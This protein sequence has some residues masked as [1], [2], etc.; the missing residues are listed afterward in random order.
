M[1]VVVSSPAVELQRVRV[2]KRGVLSGDGD[3]LLEL[4]IGQTAG[5]SPRAMAL[6]SLLGMFQLEHAP[7]RKLQFRRFACGHSLAPMAPINR[8]VSYAATR[9]SCRAGITSAIGGPGSRRA[10]MGC[11]PREAEQGSA[12]R[13]ERRGRQ[14]ANTGRG[15]AGSGVHGIR[16]GYAPDDDTGGTGPPAAAEARRGRG[17]D[18]YPGQERRS[19]RKT[20]AAPNE[21][22]A[23]LRGPWSTKCRTAPGCGR[24]RKKSGPVHNSIRGGEVSEQSTSFRG[25]DAQRPR[26]PP[27]RDSYLARCGA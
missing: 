6:T 18:A 9:L 15:A 12:Q 7:D 20:P 27:W 8:I 25:M 17:G 19:Q 24:L 13:G 4:V 14:S 5:S 2:E 23:E 16:G 1:A 26:P 21:P 22:R 10:E 3:D 11:R